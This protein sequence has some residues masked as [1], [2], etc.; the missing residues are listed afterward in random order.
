MFVRFR[1]KGQRLQASLVETRRAAGKVVTKHLGGLGSV[2]AD[3]SVRERR[4]FWDK[5]PERL[6]RIGDWIGPDECEQICAMLGTRIPMIMSEEPLIMSEEPRFMRGREGDGDGDTEIEP[7]E[8]EIRAMRGYF[9]D[10][11]AFASLPEE[12]KIV[13]FSKM[14]GMK[15]VAQL[16]DDVALFYHTTKLAKSARQLQKAL[17][18]IIGQISTSEPQDHAHLVQALRVMRRRG[19]HS[20]PMHVMAQVVG[21]FLTNLLECSIEAEPRGKV[22]PPPNRPP[23]A[24]HLVQMMADLLESVGLRVGASGGD[25]G[26]PATR[27]MIKFYAYLTKGEV[28]KPDAIKMSLTRLRTWQAKH[29]TGKRAPRAVVEQN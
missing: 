19:L 22:S 26:G 8:D 15:V 1:T 3:L 13:V 27:L 25:A 5:L 16:H 24:L 9:G 23:K 7:P 21:P 28:I 20:A 10:D 2:D 17:K 14:F 4:D 6:D 11:P 29:L 12:S 18:V